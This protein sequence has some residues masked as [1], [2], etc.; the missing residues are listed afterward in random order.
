VRLFRP[1]LLVAF[2]LAC[3]SA[4]RS[5][6]Y[7]HADC[8]F[9]RMRIDDPR[10]GGEIIT[11]HGKT[12]QFDAVECLASYY[13]A[14]PERSTVR[15]LLVSDFEHPGTLI[16]VGSARFIRVTGTGPG[17]PMGRGLVAV[18]SG[19]DV[20]SLVQ[21][22]GGGRELAWSDVT[23]GA[24][25]G[26]NVE[27]ATS[28]A[29]P[30]AAT[31]DR[32]HAIDVTPDGPVRSLRD[33]LRVVERG[34]TIVVHPGTYREATIVVSIPVTIAGQGWPVLDGEHQRQI[35]TIMADS[36]TV[37]GL[38]FRNV[39]VAFTEDLA[40]IK[41]LRSSF[42]T[43]SGNE[44]DEA[45]FGIY[46]QQSRNCLIDH[47]VLRS[48]NPRD[49]T[50]GNGIH[51]WN[52]RDVTI[53]GN[54][55]TGHRDGI[56]FEFVRQAHVREN[57]SEGNL[58]YG[59]HFMYS[60]SCEY[61]SND[62]RR[63]GAGVAVMYTHFVRMTGNRFEDN[64]GAAAYGLLLK[65][66]ADARL[67]R[68]VFSHNATGLFADAATRLVA[69]HNDFLNNGW[70]VKLQASTEDAHFSANNFAGNTFDLATNSRTN[71]A[72]FAGNYWS[73]YA[74]YDIDHDGVGDV[75]FRPVRLSSVIVAGNEPA[76]ILLRSSF[77]SLLD[78]AERILPALTPEGLADPAPAMRWV[79]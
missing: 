39:G 75:P 27:H 52:S 32:R 74:G 55:I 9:C 36:V 11:T 1:A 73:E 72:T 44:I 14:L 10:F 61:A 78:A 57:L 20:A 4:P 63:N 29:A 33:A 76:L 26:E 58:R 8:D 62:F 41:V 48:T 37:R 66:I 65:E 28:P 47:N 49:A 6:A 69:V 2:A 50:S 77:M 24:T 5:I 43:I 7:G 25:L 21:R 12:L 15:S 54:Q 18:S 59:L 16:T 31:A 71:T 51:L 19:A 40:A 23:A 56:Y 68:N 3:T 34:G 79:K 22:L 13:A 17:S 45:F 38:H 30:D 70:A 42:C 67:E 53:V 60:D 35:M 46:L 64:S